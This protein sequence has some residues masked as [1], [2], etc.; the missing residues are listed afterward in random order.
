MPE[1][2]R[3]DMPEN[4]KNDMLEQKYHQIFVLKLPLYNSPLQ[5]I[6]CYIIRGEKRSLLIDTGYFHPK[7]EKII[8]EALEELSIR[9]EELDILATH[10]HPDHVG[11]MEALASK[12][13]FLFLGAKD[14]EMMEMLTSKAYRDKMYDAAIE[15]GFNRS[16]MLIASESKLFDNLIFPDTKK[17][18]GLSEGDIIDVG[19]YQLECIETPGHSPGHICLY[20]KEHKMIFSGDHI[21]FDISPSIESRSVEDNGLEDYINSLEKIKQLD[22]TRTFC[23]HRTCGGNPYGRIEE[24]IRHHMERLDEVKTILL[25]NGPLS[26]YETASLMNWNI[27]AE[28][29]HFP[30]EQKW[31]AVGE[32]AAHLVYLLNKGKIGSAIRDGVRKYN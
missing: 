4:R 21:L 22:I 2:R 31:F 26:A 3:N 6:N 12:T 28:W 18:C 9:P 25:E 20:E 8:R 27:Q 32:A 24:I 1:T 10:F 17:L 23:G 29:N 16:D 30:L 15:L 5:D 13:S 11:Q 7:A 14:I 19:Q